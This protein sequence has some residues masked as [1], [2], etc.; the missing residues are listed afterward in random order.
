MKKRLLFILCSIFIT[1]GFVS[2]QTA[3]KTITNADL[4][5]FRQKRLAAE[6]NYRDNYERLGFPSP[7]EL[8]ER[9][10]QDS[11][12][13]SALSARI[14]RENYE[15]EQSQRMEED[16]QNQNRIL[17][18]FGNQGAYNGNGY[19][20]PFYSGGFVGYGY[21]SSNGYYYNNFGRHGRYGRYGNYGR[22]SRIRRGENFY[23]TIT[24]GTVFP[25]RGGV[26][27]N[28]NG[29]RISGSFGGGR[30]S[31]GIRGPR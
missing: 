15:R 11:K 20:S 4:E 24:P 28:T 21:G 9:N 10:E 12:D 22:L 8:A 25:P 3:K 7:E 14:E 26:R 6:Q 23:N 30:I 1:V 2:A 31:G 18:N 29:V 17:L 19:Y 16:R 27:I 13:L 5:K